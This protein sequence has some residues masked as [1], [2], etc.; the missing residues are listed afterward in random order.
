MAQAK[1]RLEWIR[2]RPVPRRSY[3][4][5]D[6]YLTPDSNEVWNL[7]GNKL[8]NFSSNPRI[9][10]PVREA[11]QDRDLWKLVSGQR[12]PRVLV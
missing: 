7:H 2:Q 11:A 6:F 10:R 5:H 1:K 12:P 3:L 9:S 4:D 8:K